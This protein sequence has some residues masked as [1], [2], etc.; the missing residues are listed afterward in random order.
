M[1]APH[2]TEGTEASLASTIAMS[3]PLSLRTIVMTFSPSPVEKHDQENDRD[4]NAQQPE[5]NTAAHEDLQ[6]M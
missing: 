4:R 3:P 2:D 6:K 5:Q 1:T